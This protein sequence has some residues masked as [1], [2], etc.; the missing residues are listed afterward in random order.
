MKRQYTG[1][2]VILFSACLLFLGACSESYLDKK[3]TGL[4]TNSQLQDAKRWNANILRGQ[5]SGIVAIT[6]EGG[7]GASGLGHSDFGQKS[8]DIQTD[9][10]SSDME[11]RIPSY[12]HF[13][14]LENLTGTDRMNAYAYMNWRYLY[15]I[16]DAT[17][18]VFRAN[19]S[20]EKAPATETVG[21]K[22]Y[23]GQSKIM[24]GFAYYYLAML[25]GPYPYAEKKSEPA[26]PIYPYDD[27]SM[28]AK[29]AT[30]EE[31]FAYAIK[32]LKEGT[33]ALKGLKYED[34]NKDNVNYWSGLGLLATVYLETGQYDLAYNTAME[35]INS[36]K[37]RLM[38]AKEADNSGF[39]S[40]QIPEFIWCVDL[41]PANT[42]ALLTFWGH[43]D[44]FTMSYA[45]V[46]DAKRINEELYN[47][48]DANDIRKHWF[49]SE[50]LPIW[51][52]YDAAR[53][54]QGDR[55]W[56]N[57]EVYMRLAEMYLIG[58]EAAARSGKLAEARALMTTL[59]SN[60]YNYHLKA[61]IKDPK[62]QEAA[63]KEATK[64]FVASVKMDTQ[65]ELL[66][67]I[68]HNWRVEMWGEGR[69]LYAK[70]RFR[71][72]MHRSSRAGTNPNTVVKWDDQRLRYSYPDR[73]YS[74]N[75]DLNR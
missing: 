34:S 3:P 7:A 58:A 67:V 42:G 35:V 41:T 73:E 57:D 43:M 29:R 11:M 10:L 61:D 55:N 32:D 28:S 52:F 70:K 47:S 9:L 44:I 36:E 46:G 20:D 13:G 22:V 6:F 51:K 24:R 15:R 21:D 39:R 38:T 25:Y 26:V 14:A 45:S 18:S 5:A 56:T 62:E 69:A 74:N 37:Y 49:D 75:P 72:D 71:V 23:Y 12:G 1:N 59:L 8:L 50:G 60:R 54:E 19:G 17:N 27:N 16:V 63:I 31:T 53:V 48:I 4:F 40:Y 30:L 65:A 68:L 64:D 33:E 66:D 2:L